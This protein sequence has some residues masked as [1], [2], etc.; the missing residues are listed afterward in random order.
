RL[1][2]SAAGLAVTNPPEGQK[3]IDLD[4][5]MVPDEG[6]RTPWG[7]QTSLISLPYLLIG[8]E[9]SFDAQSAEIAWRIMQIQQRRHDLRA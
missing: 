2:D 9:L 4:G 5:V 7:K 8:L 6:L 1:I 3:M